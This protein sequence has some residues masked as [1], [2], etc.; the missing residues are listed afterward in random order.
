MSMRGGI[1]HILLTCLA[2]GFAPILQALER[3][4]SQNPA[5]NYLLFCAG[6]HGLDGAGA[7]HK[8]PTLRNTLA[9]LLTV[10]GG[11]DYLTRVP[12]VANS[13]LTDNALAGVLNWCLE[14]FTDPARSSPA[15]PFT[16]TELKAARSQP[17]LS[18]QASRQAVLQ[19][20]GVSASA[21]K[22]SA[23]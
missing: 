19:R 21:L 16:V 14:H 2:L 15:K 17:L 11:R 3:P 6:C 12:G 10:D 20:A 8:V 13:A 1:W 18:V 7:P 23:Y 9:L 22:E 5:Q 4:E